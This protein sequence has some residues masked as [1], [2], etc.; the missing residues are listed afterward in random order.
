M[1]GK[2]G[3]PQLVL[4]RFC[5]RFVGGERAIMFLGQKLISQ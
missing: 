5:Q 3:I 1:F 2:N 4:L